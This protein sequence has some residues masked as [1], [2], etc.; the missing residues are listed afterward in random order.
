VIYSLLCLQYL[1][2]DCKCL[3]PSVTAV[4]GYCESDC[5]NLTWYIIIFSFFVLIH[6]TSEVGSMLLTLRYVH[7]PTVLFVPVASHGYQHRAH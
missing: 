3:G 4:S 6:S 5:G 7:L 1:Y 2:S